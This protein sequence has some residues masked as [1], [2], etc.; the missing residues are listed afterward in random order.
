MSEEAIRNGYGWEPTLRPSGQWDFFKGLRSN[1][2]FKDATLVCPKALLE[3]PL[4]YT[5]MSLF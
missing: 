1:W 3:V 2:V 4:H 5:Y